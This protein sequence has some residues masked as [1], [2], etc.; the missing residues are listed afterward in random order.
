[1]KKYFAA[2]ALL[3]GLS[4]C[5]SQ[6]KVPLEGTVWKL[7]QMEGIPTEA[8]TMEDDAF[9]LQFS[10]ADLMVAGRTNCNRFFGKYEL[11]G[12]EIDFEDMGMTRMACP[13]MQYE[14]MFV[15]MLDEAD[16]YKIHGEELTLSDDGRVLATFRP[17]P[18][19]K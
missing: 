13:E 6:N 18:I 1:M 4:A 8:I 9:T 7:S 16:R 15:K 5:C 11:K 17:L 3:V 12:K 10:A 2:A 19:A 14:G